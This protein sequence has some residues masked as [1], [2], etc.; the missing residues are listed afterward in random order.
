MAGFIDPLAIMLI[1]LGMGL[2]LVALY[3]LFAA[4]GKIDAAKDKLAMPAMAI[5]FFD[6]IS[7]FLMAFTWPLPGGY[8]MLFGDPLLMF[9]LLLFIGSFM[10]Y[11]GKDPSLMTILS[12]L[13]GIYVILGAYAMVVD[14]LE[15]GANF[16]PAFGLYLSSGIGALLSPILIIKPVGASKVLYYIEFIILIVAAFVAFFIGY[17]ALLHHLVSFAHYYPA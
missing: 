17:N 11:K 9:G 4:L 8:N 7:G 15:T 14:Q 6:F 16:L 2:L 3:V 10:F 5:G 12:F 1:G 13:L